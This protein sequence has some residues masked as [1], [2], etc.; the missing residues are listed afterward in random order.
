[1]AVTRA[2]VVE[3]GAGLTNSTSYV[4]VTEFEQYWINK[5]VD[6]TASGTYPI[7][8]KEAWLNDAT[9]YADLTQEWGGVQEFDTQS[10]D[11]PRLGWSD[12]NGIDIS[13]S[14][15]DAVKNGVCELAAI[16]RGV[17]TET[18]SEAG[19]SSKGIGPVSISYSDGSTESRKVYQSAIRWFRHVTVASGL[20][21]IPL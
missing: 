6:Y 5:G 14:V 4:S 7:T 3:T 15:P 19:I 10:L 20:L 16:R 8:A 21:G 9:Q 17:Q 18:V 1:M 13:E 11:I 2:F 12:V